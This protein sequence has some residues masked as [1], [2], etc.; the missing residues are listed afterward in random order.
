MITPV[1]QEALARIAEAAV[2]PERLTGLPAAI[3]AAQAI[4][5]S[6]WLKN[7]PGNNAFGVKAKPG[8]GQLLETT[9]WFT[10]SELERFLASG[11]G[12]TARKTNST[13]GGG[14]LGP[15]RTMYIV[16]DWFRVYPTLAE[17]FADHARLITEGH[18]YAEKWRAFQV[19]KNPVMLLRE[20]A[21]I[22]ATA[23]NY[24]E[25]VLKV[26]RMPE[27]EAAI[28]AARAARAAEVT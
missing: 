7:A 13:R 21:G 15:V 27:V 28:N 6:G 19:H 1:Q 18:R 26:M 2:E 17:S 11:P 16:L 10:A 4:L 24:A 23:P 14:H 9:E 25:A 12:R 22:Y 8:E 3:T 5:E 20:I